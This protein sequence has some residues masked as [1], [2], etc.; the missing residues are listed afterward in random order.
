MPKQR[1]AKPRV[2]EKVVPTTSVPAARS[3]PSPE[4]RRP[5]P[6]APSEKP[7]VRASYLEAVSLYEQGVAALQAHDYP[8]ASS[9]LRSVIARYPSEKELHERVRLYVNV[10]ERH[11]APS[12][13]TPRTP[14]E[15]VFAATLAFNAGDYDE[16]LEHLQTATRE[17]PDHDHV[18]Y[19]LATVLT[20]R[21]QSDQAVPHLLRA[22]DLN[23]ENRSM[24]RHDPDLEPLRHYDSVRAALETASPAKAD[25][26]KPLRRSR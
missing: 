6:A 22:I 11:M 13:S 5:M 9:I 14:E 18:L 15:R 8:R 24:A 2:T 3:T 10:C 17:S 16:A 21:D 4:M 7:P 19:M 1:G 20:L 12:G 26:R 23:P 25:R